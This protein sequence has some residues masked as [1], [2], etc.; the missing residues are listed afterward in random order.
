[1]LGE[2]GP[3]FSNTKVREVVHILKTNQ[4]SP[5]LQN[6]FERKHNQLHFHMANN[7]NFHFSIWGIDFLLIGSSSHPLAIINVLQSIFLRLS[8]LHFVK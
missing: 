6:V 3:L 2:S 8:T 7:V 1:M 5:D 4:N